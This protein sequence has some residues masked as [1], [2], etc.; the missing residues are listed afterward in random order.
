MANNNNP[1]LIIKY[2]VHNNNKDWLITI[3]VPN[4]NVKSNNQ[5]ID[6]HNN[7][8]VIILAGIALHIE[9]STAI[10]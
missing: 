4:N 3:N 8:S 7:I 2:V 5:Q 9:H 6:L 10:I 1:C